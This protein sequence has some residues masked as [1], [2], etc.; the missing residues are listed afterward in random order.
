MWKI[1]ENEDQIYQEI[2]RR[3]SQSA[4]VGDI[5]KLSVYVWQNASWNLIPNVMDLEVGPFGGDWVM[6]AGPSWMG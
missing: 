4:E 1:V 6:K 5:N 3:L 2:I